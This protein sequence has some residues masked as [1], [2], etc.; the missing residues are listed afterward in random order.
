MEAKLAEYYKSRQISIDEAAKM[1]KSGDIIGTAL[2]PG[3]SSQELMN[4]ILDRWEELDNCQWYDAVQ[5]IPHRLWD[6]EFARKAYGHINWVPGWIGASFRK[7]AD[8][9]LVDYIPQVGWQAPIVAAKRISFF[10]RQVAPPNDKGYI[11]LGLDTFYSARVLK[12]GRKTGVCRVAIAEVNENMPIVY[13]DTW[14]HV[15]DFDYFIEHTAPIP[16][17]PLRPEPTEREKIIG[18]YVSEFIKDGD[19]VQMGQGGLSEVIVANLDGK[20]HLGIHTEMIPPSL[21]DL[22]NRGIVDNTLKGNH[23]G[24]T[25]ATFAAG[26]KELYDFCTENPAVGLYQSDITNHPSY[27]AGNPNTVAINSALQIDL[28]G[29]LSIESSGHRQISGCGGQPDFAMGAQWS[30]GGKAI[31]VL[32]AAKKMKDGSL[33]SNIVPAFKPG[34]IS[35]VPRYLTDVIITEYGVANLRYKSIRDMGK[36]LIEIAHPDFRGELREA[37]KKIWAPIL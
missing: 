35:S 23:R 37:W 26:D 12:E 20:H 34:T 13:G 32:P 9:N 8:A 15:S 27:I 30:P 6:L 4:A 25:T 10:I 14:V 2:G 21:V 36:E 29:Q 3:T 16:E 1:V 28:A 24:I 33:V 11:N 5:M 18:G 31:T 17:Y 19:C 22:V 7:V